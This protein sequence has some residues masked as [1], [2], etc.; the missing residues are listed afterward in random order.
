MTTMDASQ[1][2]LVDLR[3]AL[4]SEHGFSPSTLSVFKASADNSALAARLAGL[5]AGA[6]G[7]VGTT[8]A[9]YV[10]VAGDWVRVAGRRQHASPTTEHVCARIL[11]GEIA[12]DDASSLHMRRIG[13]DLALFRLVE[14]GGGALTGD[15]PT[16]TDV[17]VLVQGHRRLSTERRIGL[18]HL[19]YRVAWH[20]DRQAC[21][22]PLPVWRPWLARFCGWE[23]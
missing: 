14:G 9:V 7:W 21:A 20:L 15:T 10:A 16:H 19:R 11:V 8:D 22:P 23:D 1:R 3:A 4:G 5:P 18:R 17:P 2:A 13:A 12:L 6:S